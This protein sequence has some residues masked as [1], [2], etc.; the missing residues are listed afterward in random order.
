MRTPKPRMLLGRPVRC[1][2]RAVTMRA[3]SLACLICGTPRT[4]ST[5]LCSLLTST[6]VAG[7]PESYFRQP[8]ES[9]W[10]TRWHIPR[11]PDGSF[12]YRDYVLAAVAAGSTENGVFAGRVMWGT[13]EEISAK[14]GAVHP[15]LAGSD[16]DLLTEAFGRLH[17]VHLWRGDTLAQ[18][19]SWA[20]AE[21]TNYWQAGDNVSGEPHLDL[22]QIDDLKKTVEEHNDAWRDWFAAFG[23]KPHAVVYEDLTAEML[24]V[25]RGVL[26]FLGL[27]LPAGRAIT[28]DHRR[29]ADEVNAEWIARYRTAA[30]Q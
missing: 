1:L 23:I 15:Q 28:S 29:Q 9:T 3:D 11:R 22:G 16:L 26:D 8:D 20:R 7:R 21:Q 5:L 17:F 24:S 6:G 13:L 12:D 10:A 19:V 25:T 27:D 2:T 30:P 18:A 4:G 14:L